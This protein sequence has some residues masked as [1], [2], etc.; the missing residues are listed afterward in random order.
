MS[1][2][3]FFADSLKV[4][5]KESSVGICTLWTERENIIRSLD[6]GSYSVAGNLY[7]KHGVNALI[8][9]VLA[10]PRIRHIIICGNDLSGS[11]TALLA[12]M[13]GVNGAL[14][15]DGDIRPEHVELFRKNVS[16]IDLRGREADVGSTAK[17]LPSLPP[18]A[19]PVELG[20]VRETHSTLSSAKSG[21]HI[22][23][24]GIA[25][26]WLKIL[27]NV[28]K[29]GEEK[30]SE[31]GIAQKEVL[32][33]MAVIEGDDDGIAPWLSFTDEDLQKYYPTVLKGQKAPGVAYT[34]GERLMRHPLL[35]VGERWQDEVSATFNQIEAAYEHLKAAPYTRRA[36]AFTWNVELDSKS[37]H[38]PCLTQVSWN[39]KNGRLCQTAV[40]RSND[41]FGAWPMNAFALRELQKRMAGRLGIE[42]G[43][44]IIIS[45]SAHIYAN[46]WSEA[47]KILDKYYTGGAEEFRVDPLGYFVVS[48]KGGEIAVQ[49]HV[50]DGRPSQFVFRGKSAIELYRSIV[51]ENLLSKFDHAA[52]IGKELARAEAALKSGQPYVQ[53]RA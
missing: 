46:N 9:N 10:N 23:E 50:P 11:G 38:P 43:H 35:G 17:K 21:F 1:W 48:V 40:I 27:D 16:V 5:N 45:N 53:D 29:F 22:S 52:Y 44:M 33:L 20:E 39:V 3:L 49:H 42:S 13:A 30:P 12:W 41:M 24:K 7:T 8:K 26:A 34:Y 28:M 36:M 15:L 2:P 19:E 4:G 47:R 6:E 32:D 31:Y 37:G 18:F 25:S 51:H 14:P